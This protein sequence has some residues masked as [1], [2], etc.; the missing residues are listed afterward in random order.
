VQAH[1]M[2]HSEEELKLLKH[3][4]E[5]ANI[6]LLILQREGPARSAHKPVQ[7]TDCGMA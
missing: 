4:R 7:L 3:V 5:K 6:Y 1:T 2:T